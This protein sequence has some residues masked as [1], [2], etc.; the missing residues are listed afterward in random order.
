MVAFFRFVVL[1]PTRGGLRTKKPFEF[2]VLKRENA[3]LL[4]NFRFGSDT[5]PWAGQQPPAGPGLGKV[6]V[7]RWAW[8]GEG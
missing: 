4:S 2:Q 5:V 6:D 1:A 7:T 3:G 8:S